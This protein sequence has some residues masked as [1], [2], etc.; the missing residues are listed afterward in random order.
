[1]PR[2]VGYVPPELL[3]FA[4]AATEVVRPRRESGA[5]ELDDQ[6]DGVERFH[7]VLRVYLASRTA[8]TQYIAGRGQLLTGLS[9]RTT[10][11]RDSSGGL[12]FSG[13]GRIV[14]PGM[15]TKPNEPGF[16]VELGRHIVADSQICGGQ[17]TFK[18]TRILVWA[19]L[20]QLED[21]RTWDE[22]VVEWPGKVSKA[23]IAEAIAICD[24]VEKHEPFKGFHVGSRRKP[25][26]QPAVLAA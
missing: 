7:G 3:D 4:V 5:Q 20:E 21:G 24:L 22:V 23:A 2:S 25:A 26:R 15:K 6:G 18:G 12:P 1:V 16:R 19:V 13:P 17:P 11:L 9:A 10:G 8:F 14:V